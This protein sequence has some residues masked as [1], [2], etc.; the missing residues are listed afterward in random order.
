MP[1]V[2]LSK[3]LFIHISRTGGTWTWDVLRRLGL[4]VRPLPNAHTSLEDL[5]SSNFHNRK[6][7]FA[8]VRHPLEW[9]RSFYRFCLTKTKP[10]TA[11]P[12]RERFTRERL[13][14]P[15]A[16]VSFEQF[17]EY[18]VDRCPGR[19]TKLYED[20]TGLP[21]NEIEFIGHYE[22]LREDLWVALRM[23][24]EPVGA[25]AYEKIMSDPPINASGT[26]AREGSQEPVTSDYTSKMAQVVCDSERGAIERFYPKKKVPVGLQHGFRLAHENFDKGTCLEF[27]VYEGTSFLWQAQQIAN[28]YRWSKLIGFDSWAGLP[29]ENSNVWG[30]REYWTGRFASPRQVVVDRLATIK[31]LP[32]GQCSLVDGWFRD[33]LTDELAGTIT[34]LIHVNIDSDLYQSAMEVLE[35]IG[36]LLRPGV[37]IHWDEWRDPALVDGDRKWG[38]HLAWEHWSDKHPDIA[39]EF[40]EPAQDWNPRERVMVIKEVQ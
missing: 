10:P 36:P 12:W 20:Q 23:A 4:S 40:V 11:A 17:I 15:N 26:H 9:Y 19:L 7:R 8:F 13:A 32:S 39:V 34:D 29:E 22:T 18:V 35:F 27:G 30:P 14:E 33:T 1:N 24:G 16:G 37:V 3:S 6:F 21:D 25:E 28:Q 31:H 5:R 38:E 2:L